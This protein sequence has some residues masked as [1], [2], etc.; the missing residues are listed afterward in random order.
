MP[1]AGP[2]RSPRDDDSGGGTDAQVEI[3]VS[4]GATVLIRANALSEGMQGAYTLQVTRR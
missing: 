1:D 2:R 4:A 3:D